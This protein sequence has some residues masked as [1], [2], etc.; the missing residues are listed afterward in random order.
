[1]ISFQ[2][3]IFSQSFIGNRWYWWIRSTALQ[4]ARHFILRVW[5][6]IETRSSIGGKV[7]ELLYDTRIELFH[8]PIKR[9]MNVRF[10]QLYRRVKW[11]DLIPSCSSNRRSQKLFIVHKIHKI[12]LTP[13]KMIRIQSN[14]HTM[15]I[16]AFSNLPPYFQPNSWKKI[17]K[18]TSFRIVNWSDDFT[19]FWQRWHD[20]EKRVQQIQHIKRKDRTDKSRSAHS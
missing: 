14:L 7:F 11:V 12:C 8:T 5:F 19:N 15:I 9:C 10:K 4:K 20:K 17:L 16:H 6:L 18:W 13:V 3:W 2:R 1:M